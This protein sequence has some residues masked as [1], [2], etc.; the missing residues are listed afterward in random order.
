MAEQGL[1]D[2]LSGETVLRRHFEAGLG[3]L[4]ERGGLNLFVLAMANACFDTRVWRSLSGRLDRRFEQ[5][6]TG[7][8]QALRE[9]CS[10][11]EA[12]EDLLV[13]L[14]LATI[15]LRNVAPTGIRH[16]GPWEL[17]FNPIR[18]FR[19]L[20]NARRTMNSLRQP[21]DAQGFHFNKPFMQEEVI[22]SGELLG[23]KVDLYYN[24]YPFANLHALLVPGREACQPQYLDQDSHELA[25]Q[26]L[27]TFGPGLPG[28]RVGYNAMG[29]FASVNHL[30][31][32]LCVRA[33]PLPVEDG[34]WRHNGGQEDYPVA[35]GLFD[36]AAAAWRFIDGLHRAGQPYNL[37]YA[38]G[39]LYVLQRRYQGGFDLPVWSNGFSWYELSGAMITCNREQW[40]VLDANVVA[41]ALARAALPAEHGQQSGAG[42][43]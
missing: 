30:H 26:L 35:C 24:K 32:Q 23:R 25:W 5:L 19:P 1:A 13:F 31:L 37:L 9:G 33:N 12:D 34:R 39:R 16:A 20:R 22:A 42:G 3:R 43:C 8:R 40:Q 15:G 21:F 10:I 4:L 17:Q 41:A 11:D 14:K 6:Q 28:L 7:V 27:E 38:P 18:A 2:L 36:D 29:A